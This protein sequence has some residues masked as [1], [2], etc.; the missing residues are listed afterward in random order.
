MAV[1]TLTT[2]QLEKLLDAMGNG[3]SWPQITDDPQVNYA[4]D[5]LT[6][7]TALE[8]EYDEALYRREIE[9][10]AQLK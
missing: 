6:D 3:Q 5:C 1:H 7:D 2:R 4:V 8:P 10:F 9:A